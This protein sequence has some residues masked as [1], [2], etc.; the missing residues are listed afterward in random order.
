M[1]ATASAGTA[2]ISLQR[3]AQGRV[4]RAVEEQLAFLRAHPEVTEIPA[5][6]GFEK[7]I[8]NTEIFKVITDSIST[9]KGAPKLET[10][11]CELHK[12]DVLKTIL[13]LPR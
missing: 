8:V 5:S 4:Y 3:Q 13:S 1:T 7:G 12:E 10:V 11:L 9:R 6:F 2:M